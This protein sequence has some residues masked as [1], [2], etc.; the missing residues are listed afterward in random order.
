MG[1][2]TWDGGAGTVGADQAMDRVWPAQT[3]R[4]PAAVPCAAP[5][6]QMLLDCLAPPLRAMA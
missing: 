3:T 1:R 4:S 5:P 2:G 6:S